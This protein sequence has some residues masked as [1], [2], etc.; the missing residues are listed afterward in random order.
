MSRAPAK[1]ARRRRSPKR[2]EALRATGRGVV[3]PGTPTGWA[4]TGVHRP[5]SKRHGR[6]NAGGDLAVACMRTGAAVRRGKLTGGFSSRRSGRAW[7]QW[8][9]GVAWAWS[10]TIQIALE[11]GVRGQRDLRPGAASAA[12]VASVVTYTLAEARAARLRAGTG[13]GRLATRWPGTRL[14]RPVA[15]TVIA[16][17]PSLPWATKPVAAASVASGY[18]SLAFQRT[19][20]GEMYRRPSRTLAGS[21]SAR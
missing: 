16:T 19:L 8:L 5:G 10:A 13:P 2:R 14:P 20:T 6:T 17:V 4:A 11:V 12:G 18:A 3:Q 7:D 21:S 9:P 15:A 1:C